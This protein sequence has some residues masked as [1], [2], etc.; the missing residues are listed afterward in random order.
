MSMRALERLGL[1]E[2]AAHYPD[3]LS[4]RERQPNQ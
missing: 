3:Q 4:G 1:G 2:R